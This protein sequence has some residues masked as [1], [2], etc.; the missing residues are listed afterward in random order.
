M[1]HICVHC[2]QGFTAPM[3]FDSLGWH[4]M[5]PHCGGSFDVT[6]DPTSPGEKFRT[7]RKRAAETHGSAYNSG[8]LYGYA[9]ALRE[10]T[11]ARYYCISCGDPSATAWQWLT[12][13][14]AETH[15]NAGYT[16]T[17]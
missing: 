16:L 10:I 7:A 2:T 13:D 6:P 9:D 15:R 4:T 14:E 11:G 5:C 3:Y 1:K 12:L 17:E 8:Y